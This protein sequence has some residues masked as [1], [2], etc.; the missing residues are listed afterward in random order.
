MKLVRS[1]I[2]N[3]LVSPFMKL[4]LVVCVGL[5]FALGCGQFKTKDSRLDRA[6]S[7][8]DHRRYDE[9]I[10]LLTA[11]K[12]E[13]PSDSK[14]SLWLAEAHFGRSGFELFRFAAS[15]FSEQ[16]PQSEETDL[17]KLPTCDT[18]EIKKLQG[19]D[20][21]CVMLRV[22]RKLPNPEHPDYIK[23]RVILRESFPDPKAT[24]IDVN[25]LQAVVELGSA[26]G[27]IKLLAQEA[28]K[29]DR[30]KTAQRLNLFPFEF[31]VH[32]VKGFFNEFFYGLLRARHSYSK[33]S[34]YLVKFDGKPIIKI[35]SQTLVFNDQITFV[36]LIKFAG[37][38][39]R[40]KSKKVDEEL[41]DIAEGTIN[42][43]GSG[44]I[45]TLE[46][47]DLV[48]FDGE[49]A[50][51]VEVSFKFQELIQ[52]VLKDLEADVEF[53]VIE[54]IWKKP[55]KILADLMPSFW[56][57]WRQEKRD[58]LLSYFE[59]TKTAWT[60]FNNLVNRWDFLM[61]YIMTKE[62][63]DGL[64]RSLKR[65]RAEHPGVIVGPPSQVTGA[66]IEKW[67]NEF[68]NGMEKFL[69]AW[70]EGTLP[71]PPTIRPE[72]AIEAK[73]LLDLSLGWIRLNLWAP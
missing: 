42:R 34:T 57:A 4:S 41:S 22:Y 33:V 46:V 62:E 19:I 40:E 63:R 15:I 9:A 29:V 27:R 67:S 49:A 20:F 66:E 59:R 48:H 51:R 21:R 25:F 26:L 65:Y 31:F 52:L 3:L 69:L 47:F 8:L 73:K 7:A 54:M 32:H 18:K 16:Q 14:V 39:L 36:E 5:T 58:P 11:M 6:R 1:F 70:I 61:T 50:R 30:R 12:A 64:S 23:G 37:K 72:V 53:N 55:P 44:I 71:D 2:T 35:G 60:E 24:P 28:I 13:N 56:E 10:E 45:R 43:L 38:V 17:L 68:V